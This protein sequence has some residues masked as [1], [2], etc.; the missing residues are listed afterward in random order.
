MFKCEPQQ[1]VRRLMAY[2]I[3]TYGLVRLV[4]G[5]RGGG[6][7]R[8]ICGATYVLEGFILEYEL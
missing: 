3:L 8:L 6:P 1:L 2:W 7:T 5:I 4:A